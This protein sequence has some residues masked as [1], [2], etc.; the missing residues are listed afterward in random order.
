VTALLTTP[1][2]ALRAWGPDDLPAFFDLYSRWDV[3]RWLG[4]HPRRA[5]AD[6]A[7]AQE[8]LAHWQLRHDAVA[9]PFGRWALVPTAPL[10][11]TAAPADRRGVPVGS[12]LLLPLQDATGPTAV[13]EVGW[14]LHPS[15]QG[16]GLVTEAASALLAV[17]AA[18]GI[19]PVIAVT[20]PEN[21]RSQ[22]VAR[23]LGMHDRGLSDRWFGLTTRVFA[24]DPDA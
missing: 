13:V 22:A 16:H 5:I 14:H 8:R 19:G 3:M 24:L 4:T 15:W 2:T 10:P 9:D 12:V 6:E 20:D 18:A 23:R 17:A 21:E 1:R 7:E 11:G